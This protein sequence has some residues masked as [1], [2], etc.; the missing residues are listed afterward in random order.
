MKQ[1]IVKKGKVLAETIPTPKVDKGTLLIK[2]HYSCISA[3]TEMTSVNTSKQSLVKRALNSPEEVKT[4][5]EFAKENGV[6][7]T[8]QR[9]RGVLDGGKQ[10]G[11]SIA[12]EVIEVGEGVDKFQVGDKIAAAGAGIA[13]HAEFV[14][15]PENLTMLMPK[16]MDCK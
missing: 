12:G 15:V 5:I 1:G 13:N 7:K 16:G 3:G 4:A 10:T 2:V 14:S 9:V 8:I 11:Y 6:L